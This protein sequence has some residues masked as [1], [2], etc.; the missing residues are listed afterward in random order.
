MFSFEY[1]RELNVDLCFS[2]C[3]KLTD[4]SM[5]VIAEHCP[6]LCALDIM[7]LSKLTDS[8][9]VY[10][11]NGCQALQLLKL[12][13]NAFRCL[14]FLFSCFVN[15]S[16]F[17]LDASCVHLMFYYSLSHMI[18]FLYVNNDKLL[19]GASTCNNM[20]GFWNV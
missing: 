14:V 8:S 5:K 11:T 2:M 15:F 20:L 6:Q 4:L 18:L 3:R 7:N 13:C 16:L 9:M 1:L 19:I 12:C 17:L 10:L